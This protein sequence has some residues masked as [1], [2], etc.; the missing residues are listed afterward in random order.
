MQRTFGK[1]VS[2]YLY[3]QP[4]HSTPRRG[5]ERREGAHRRW[6]SQKVREVEGSEPRTGLG[7]RER[8][9]SMPGP[10]WD[11]QECP[12]PDSC[13]GIAQS[14][15]QSISSIS[16][17]LGTAPVI[18]SMCSPHTQSPGEAKKGEK[19]PTEGGRGVPSQPGSSYQG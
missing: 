1:Y 16:G 17:H 9:M 14:I 18:I 8:T 15:S 10:S 19:E 13:P 5:K 6:E 7:G 11:W 4:S 12:T 3:M 2:D